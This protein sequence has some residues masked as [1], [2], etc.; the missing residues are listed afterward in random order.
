MSDRTVLCLIKG[1][2]PLLK[3]CIVPE[4]QCTPPLCNERSLEPPGFPWSYGQLSIQVSKALVRE[5]TKS[6]MTTLK[7]LWKLGR[8]EGWMEPKTGMSLKK[9]WL[10]QLRPRFE[11]HR[12][13]VNLK[14]AVHRCSRFSLIEFQFLIFSVQSLPA[15]RP[16]ILLLL[17]TEFGLKIKRWPW[18]DSSELQLSFLDI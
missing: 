5:V 3:L 11:S 9:T 2:K 6:P 10:V 12:A 8:K 4:S 1:I 13:S 18:N 15:A 14:M 7:E 16:N 17:D